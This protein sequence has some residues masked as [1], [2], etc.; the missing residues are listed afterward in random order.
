LRSGHRLYR[1]RPVAGRK[2][3]CSCWS[4]CGPSCAKELGSGASAE[5]A[6][7]LVLKEDGFDWGDAGVGAGIGIAAMLAG[8]AGA[9]EARRHRIL[10][11]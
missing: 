1:R 4:S 11:R 2:L 10:A 5:P 7:R 6:Q 9:F 3:G 8:V